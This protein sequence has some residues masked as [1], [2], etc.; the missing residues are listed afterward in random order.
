MKCKKVEKNL[1]AFLEKELPMKMQSEIKN[2]L[3]ECSQC[4]HLVTGLT[5]FWKSFDATE[6]IEPSPYFWNKLSL[7]IAQQVERRY[8][9]QEIFERGFRVLVPIAGTIILVIGLVVGNYLGRSLYSTS[10]K[11]A[12]RETAIL[13]E[14]FIKSLHL[15]TFDDLPPESVGRIYLSLVSRVK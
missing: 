14:N 12:E 8:S 13:E 10:L 11:T 4:S 6:R 3:K 9:F 7:K 15:S 5:Q 1:A 2:H